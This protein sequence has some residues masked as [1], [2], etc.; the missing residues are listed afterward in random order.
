MAFC[1]VHYSS[2]SETVPKLR[3]NDGS[4]PVDPIA[5]TDKLF[6]SFG[7]DYMS[8]CEKKR[9]CTVAKVR[10]LDLVKGPSPER[11]ATTRMRRERTLS[12]RDLDRRNHP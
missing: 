12:H 5:R 2:T 4:I 9:Q 8:G 3:A 1:A 6:R 10:K 7:E 11:A